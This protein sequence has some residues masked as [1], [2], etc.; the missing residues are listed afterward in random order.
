VWEENIVVYVS[1]LQKER[2]LLFLSLSPFFI[3]YFI[4]FYIGI[5]IIINFLQYSRALVGYGGE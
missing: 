4:L 1:I 2:A 3:F 5:I